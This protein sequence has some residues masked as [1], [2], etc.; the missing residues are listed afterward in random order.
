MSTRN[1]ALLRIALLGL[2]VW[3]GW[4]VCVEAQGADAEADI[5]VVDAK[6]GFD[7]HVRH[8]TFVPLR[9][10][11]KNHEVQPRTL[12]LRLTRADAFNAIGESIE[13]EIT[14]SADTTRLVQ[15]T[16]FVSDPGESWTLRWGESD[17]E[18]HTIKGISADDGICLI[19]SSQELS[20]R[21]GFLSAMDED[22]FPT[23]VTAL[24]ALRF[25]FLDHEPRWPPPRRKALEEWL[26]KGGTVVVLNRA[27]GKAPEFVEMPFL[28]TNGKVTSYGQGVILRLQQTP[29]SITKKFLEQQIL[30]RPMTSGDLD[31]RLTAYEQTVPQGSSWWNGSFKLPTYSRDQVLTQLMDV[32]G[33]R[34]RWGLI[35]LTLLVYV[36]WQWRVGWRWGLMEKQPNR[37]YAWLFV[38]AVAF[39]LI[40]YF[41]GRTG[42]GNDRVRSI[43]VAKRIS[44]GLFD[45]EG[46]AV[47][48]T[49][50]TGDRKEISFPGTGQLYG[51]AESFGQNPITIRDGKM[52]VELNAFSS[53]RLAFRTRIE[54]PDIPFQLQSAGPDMWQSK[55]ARLVIDPAY[56]GN[57]YAAVVAIGDNLY[58]F[59][60][61]HGA[62]APT[63]N[64]SEKTEYWLHPQ[65]PR[66]NV[67]RVSIFSKL[68]DWRTNDEVYLEAFSSVVGNGFK[69]GTAVYPETFVVRPG[70]ARVMLFVDWPQEMNCQGTF[71]DQGGRMLYVQDV[72]LGGR[73]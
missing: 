51:G 47:L 64:W 20:Q 31:Q 42:F 4:A 72:P 54:M 71:G 15:M 18:S 37:H 29:V 34:Q 70:Y 16:P 55:S 48:A 30:G 32:A 27:D 38:L 7:G 46:W 9:I 57:V 2:A 33:T 41:S 63:T 3:C 28:N 5:Q 10:L 49:S 40:F 52:A 62:L 60:P 61:K 56:R 21:T 45:V 43:I 6:W 12:L 69:V 23:S 26:L 1:I 14:I 44:P 66:R 65:N 11:I 25:L 13:Q 58:E 35:Y 24:D 59:E 50:L 8:K 36:G 17:L 53:Q 68:F 22:E 73:P 67:W 19:T 39:S